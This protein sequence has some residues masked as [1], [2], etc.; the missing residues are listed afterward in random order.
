ML[1]L[2]DIKPGALIQG[3]EP[4]EVVR[5][6]TSEPIGPNALTVYYKK[7]NGSLLERLIYRTDV[8]NLAL[9][10]SGRPW[11]FDAPGADFKLAV[12]ACRINLAYLFDP[13]MAVHT[14]NIEPLPH[15]I[16][17]CAISLLMIPVPER[18]SWQGCICGN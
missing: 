17:P 16:T 13:M 11:S 10:I 4:G 14:S 1:R 9:A 3:L 5:V 8:M 2:E 7:N 18:L 15:Q 12:E 6:V